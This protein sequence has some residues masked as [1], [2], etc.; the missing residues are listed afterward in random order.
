MKSINNTENISAG[1]IIN[2]ISRAG[3][4]YFQY[5]FRKF[6]IGY[7]QIRTLLYIAQSEG[8]TQ[9]ELAEYRLYL[10]CFL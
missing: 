10:R 8:K 4:V 9:K 1:R 7:A 3:H 5:E 6:N 2:D